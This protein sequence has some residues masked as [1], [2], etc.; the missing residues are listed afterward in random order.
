[1]IQGLG[2]YWPCSQSLESGKTL[3]ACLLHCAFQPTPV[4]LLAPEMAAWRW[5]DAATGAIA[6]SAQR[7]ALEISPADSVTPVRPDAIRGDSPGGP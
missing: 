6:R 1:M 2:W 5:G 3:C 7:A 4:N